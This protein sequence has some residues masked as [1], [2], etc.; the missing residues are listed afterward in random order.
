MEK[1]LNYKT[2]VHNWSVCDTRL[3]NYIIEI[4]FYFVLGQSFGNVK[5]S[6]HFELFIEKNYFQPY[7][8][9]NCL[10]STI[11]FS[12]NPWKTKVVNLPKLKLNRKMYNAVGF[13]AVLKKNV[14][15]RHF[16]TN[17]S[18][19]PQVGNNPSTV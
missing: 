6:R 16:N 7:Q 19:V 1:I 11:N 5:I 8:A 15:Q 13:L 10:G 18:V 17:K 14:L 4:V 12:M 3:L 2:V 9:I